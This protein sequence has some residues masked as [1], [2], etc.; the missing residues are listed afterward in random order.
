[1][2]E[3]VN[4]DR[5]DAATGERP[6]AGTVTG[7]AAVAAGAATQ[8]DAESRP[9]FAALIYAPWEGGPVPADVPPVFLAAAG[10]D[11][12]VDVRSSLALFSAWRAVA[13]PAELHVYSKGGHG[14]G[15]IKQGLQSDHWPDPFWAWLKAHNFV[16]SSPG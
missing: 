4:P 16:P 5:H 10:D 15:L 11:D 2:P 8:Y 12:L 9:S 7:W 1:M 3:G 14:F 6:A 13:R